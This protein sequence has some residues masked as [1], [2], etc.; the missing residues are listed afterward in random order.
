MAKTI[1][2]QF[3]IRQN[4]SAPEKSINLAYFENGT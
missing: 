3:P 1:G 4:A 2:R